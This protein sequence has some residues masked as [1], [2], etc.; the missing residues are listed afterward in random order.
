MFTHETRTPIMWQKCP[1]CEGHGYVQGG[2][3]I[4]TPG[5]DGISDST[6]EQCRTCKGRGIITMIE[7]V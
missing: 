4:T 3:Y 2:F 1:V 6:S 5:S 7:D